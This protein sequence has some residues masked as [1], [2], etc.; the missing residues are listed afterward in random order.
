MEVKQT[1]E[2]PKELYDK[3]NE[4]GLIPNNVRESNIGK[5]NYSKHTIQPWSIWLDYKLNAWDADIVKRILRTKEEPGMS[6]VESRKMDYTKIVHICNERLRQL[7]FETNE[8]SN[9]SEPLMGINDAMEPIAFSLIGEEIKRYSDFITQH[10]TCGGL[11]QAY[12]SRKGGIG[13]A[14]KLV[15]PICGHTKDITDYSLW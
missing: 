8:V 10:K 12:V 15:C 11:V 7:E 3:F 4:L 5:S 14:V 6:L 9:V 13:Q 2:I 1:V